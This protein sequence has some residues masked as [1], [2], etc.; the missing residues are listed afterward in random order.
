M[1]PYDCHSHVIYTMKISVSVNQAGELPA[2]VE[3]CVCVCV[4]VRACVCVHVHVWVF[5]CVCACV[6]M[7]LKGGVREESQ[8]TLITPV[9]NQSQ[10]N[11]K[12]ERFIRER[13]C[14]NANNL[15]LRNALVTSACFSE[16]TSTV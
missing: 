15:I 16:L 11:V 10:W 8:N 5:A 1:T 12:V 4:C 3:K 2:S 6:C 7:E 13:G 9:F 14:Q